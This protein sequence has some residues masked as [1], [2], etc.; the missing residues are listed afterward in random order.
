MHAPEDTVVAVAT[1]PGRGGIAAIRLSGPAAH[2]VASSLFQERPGTPAPGSGRAIFGTFLARDGAALDRGYLVRFAPGGSFTGEPVAE[3][4]THG[5][6]AVLRELVAGAIEAGASPAAPGEFTYRAMRNGRLDLARAEAIRDLIAARTLWQA[7]VAHAQSEGAVSRRLEPIRGALADLVARTEAAVEFVEESDV[8]LPPGSLREGIARAAE[9][10]RTLLDGFRAGRV[11]REGAVVAITGLPNVGKSSLFNALLARERAIVSETAGTTRDTIEEEVDIEGLP[12]RLIDTAGL[13]E[14]LD[15]VEG[16]GVRRAGAAARESDLVIVVL[17]TGRPPSDA[18]MRAI[19][20]A[21]AASTIVVRNKADLD[22]VGGG[23]DTGP[24]LAVSATTGAGLGA[25]RAALR[26]RLIGAER[27][28]DPILTDA[29]HAAALERASAALGRALG[30]LRE[31][32]PEEYVLEDLRAAI[33][34]VGEI[35]GAFGNE[36]LY[37]KIFATFCIGK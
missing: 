12:V 4:W 7:R 27:V 9:D 3:L 10:V 18:E 22:D 26:E 24:G 37:E 1:P 16:E 11:V 33:D 14:T 5:S 17:E 13:R 15:P 30:A 31:G 28:E 35:T 20:E 21:P 2:A 19:R 6:P 25:L 8:H 29:R 36:E 23:G 34:N 32:F